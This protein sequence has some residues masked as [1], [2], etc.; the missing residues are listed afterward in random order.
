MRKSVKLGAALS[1]VTGMAAAQQGVDCPNAQDMF[2]TIEA[3]ET[4]IHYH[5]LADGR[6]LETEYYPGEAE[7]WQYLVSPQG[8]TLENWGMSQ[9]RI[10][11]GTH[12]IVTLTS[13]SG[14]PGVPRPFGSW[15]GQERLEVAGYPPDINTITFTYGGETTRRIGNC[16][17]TV[18]P[19]TFVVAASPDGTPAFHGL[20]EFIPEL[21]V[22]IYLGGDEEG[23]TPEMNEP[24][25]ISRRPPGAQPIGDRRKE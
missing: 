23:R 4:I 15:T 25:S 5:R 12:E 2:F 9:G 3:A 24:I 18:I 21:G 8:F 16:T 1:L 13:R 14:P 11:D 19:S 17:Y 7:P 22:G 20:S 10:E 6:V